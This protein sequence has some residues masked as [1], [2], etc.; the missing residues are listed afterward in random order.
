M[1]AGWVFGYLEWPTCFATL[2]IATQHENT[3]GDV[4]NDGRKVRF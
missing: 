3:V 4:E 1:R 2:F